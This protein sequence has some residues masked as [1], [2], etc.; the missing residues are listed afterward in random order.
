MGEKVM[1]QL[2]KGEKGLSYSLLD[3]NGGGGAAYFRDTRQK[4]GEE[5]DQSPADSCILH[6][7]SSESKTDCGAI[8]LVPNQSSAC[9]NERCQGRID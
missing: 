3:K 4:P 2:R 5:S 7:T 9:T 8:H 6:C 1:L